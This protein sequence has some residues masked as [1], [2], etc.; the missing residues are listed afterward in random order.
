MPSNIVVPP[1]TDREEYGRKS[2][3]AEGG[4]F[5]CKEGEQRRLQ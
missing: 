5:R 1:F 3:K 2:S 4:K